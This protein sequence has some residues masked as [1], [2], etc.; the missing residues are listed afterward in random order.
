VLVWKR[1]VAIT[2]VVAMVAPL[3]IGAIVVVTGALR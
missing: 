2:V 3:V 1:A